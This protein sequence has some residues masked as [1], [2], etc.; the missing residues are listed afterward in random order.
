MKKITKM[1]K[2]MIKIMMKDNYLRTE[3]I[4]YSSI[5]FKILIITF[6]NKK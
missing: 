1:K 3:D 6:K 5:S 2:T 4:K